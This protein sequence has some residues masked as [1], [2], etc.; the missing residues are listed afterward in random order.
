MSTKKMSFITKNY[1][2]YKENFWRKLFELQ[3][4]APKVNG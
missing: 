3:T 2:K 1:A 4:L